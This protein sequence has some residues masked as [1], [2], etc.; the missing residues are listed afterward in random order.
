MR[1]PSRT[2]LLALG[3]SSIALFPAIAQPAPPPLSPGV[4]T[5]YSDAQRAADQDLSRR[6]V[7]SLLAPPTSFENQYAK[8][9][10][11]VCVNVYGLAALSKYM[12]ERRIRQVAQQ[13][14]AP[15]DR[16]DPCTPNVT[17]AVT[18]DPQGT[19]DSVATAAPFLVVSGKKRQLTVTQPVQA[20]YTTFRR[21]FSGLAQLD[22]NWED[23]A[24]AGGT[25]AAGGLANLT[26]P[27]GDASIGVAGGSEPA[28]AAG[29]ATMQAGDTIERDVP[30]VRAQGTRLSTGI[31]PEMAAAL[32]IVDAKAIMG[33][34][35]GSIADY[36]ALLTL[37][38]AP[39]TGRCQDAP[40]IANL[41]VNCSAD[42]KTT[43]LSNVDIALLTG[44]YETP[45]KPEMI[46]RARIIGAMRRTLE[47]QASR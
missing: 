9:T 2:A 21:D 1:S 45:L 10:R 25:E 38:Q 33:M 13:V 39:A 3:A 36:L 30:R 11:P 34:D 8:W 18:E 27:S 37:S 24:T 7:G 43:A 32:I 16:A 46:Q 15:V 17:I 4:E 42:V 40:S 47:A 20:W 35:L 5:V 19:L 29:M 41:M 22:L 28:G 26:P 23:A 6:F 12:V 31:T 44:L 14:G